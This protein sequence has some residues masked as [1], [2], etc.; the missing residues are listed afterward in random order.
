MNKRERF[1]RTLIDQGMGSTF[2]MILHVSG[3]NVRVYQKVLTVVL[4]L[5]IY[6]VCQKASPI[7]GGDEWRGL[8][9]G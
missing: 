1:V 5:T 7:R 6:K 3:G 2:I 8:L 9:G 4:F